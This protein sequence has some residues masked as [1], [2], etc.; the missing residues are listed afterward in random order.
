MVD[1]EVYFSRRL[2]IYRLMW[3]IPCLESWGTIQQIEQLPQGSYIPKFQCQ[4]MFDEIIW[5]FI[6]KSLLFSFSFWQITLMLCA[7]RYT[8]IF[9]R[10]QLYDHLMNWQ[11][12]QKTKKTGNM[13]NK[14]K[15]LVKEYSSFHN[16]K[17]NVYQLT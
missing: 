11:K 7:L 12:K 1:F 9:P 15:K 4:R 10:D 3:A 2:P 14:R 16:Q 13:P 6:M 17:S 5:V 8:I